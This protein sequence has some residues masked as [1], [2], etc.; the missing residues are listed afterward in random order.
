MTELL[1]MS[2]L[3][4]GPLFLKKDTEELKEVE[5]YYSFQKAM[6]GNLKKVKKHTIWKFR[7]MELIFENC[8]GRIHSVWTLYM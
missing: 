3:D 2:V 1:T 8:F 7:Q 6:Q 4:S 5:S